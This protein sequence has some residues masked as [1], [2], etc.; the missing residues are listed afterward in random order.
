MDIS[1]NS[2][3]RSFVRISLELIVELTDEEALRAAA[4][5]SV[6]TADYLSDEMRADALEA[7]EEDIAEA[8]T[9]LIDP[10]V[11][12]DDVPG[13]EA[14]EAEWV[15]ELVEYDPDAVPHPGPDGA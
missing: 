12:I 15:S 4:V 7:I 14:H 5:E 3:S 11:L 8:V 6:R 9:H 2:S 10:H 1:A 13:V